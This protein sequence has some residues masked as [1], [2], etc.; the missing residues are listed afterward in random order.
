MRVCTNCEN[1]DEYYMVKNE[2]WA[3]YGN[4]GGMLCIGC[5]E[6]RMDRKLTPDDFVDVPI[7]YLVWNGINMEPPYKSDRLLNRLELE[8]TNTN[9][10][11]D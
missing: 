1:E 10:Q 6:E 3:Q 9:E 2:I 4:G 11:I 8:R 7:N 5:L